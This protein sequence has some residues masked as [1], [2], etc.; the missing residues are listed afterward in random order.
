MAYGQEL[1]ASAGEIDDNGGSKPAMA[2]RFHALAKML[3]EA[4]QASVTDRN[5]EAAEHLRELQAHCEKLI[6]ILA[7]DKKGGPTLVAA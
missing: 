2:M 5:S 6:T 7:P 1:W 3:S 4:Q